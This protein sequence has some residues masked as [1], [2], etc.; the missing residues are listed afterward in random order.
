MIYLSSVVE[1][2]TM[3]QSS[4]RDFFLLLTAG[5]FL[6]FSLYVA[7]KPSED[8]PPDPVKRKVIPM[9]IE[10]DNKKIVLQPDSQSSP[11]VNEI[12][13]LQK[14]IDELKWTIKEQEKESSQKILTKIDANEKSLI[15]YRD[16]L[17]ELKKQEQQL[18]NELEDLKQNK[19]DAELA[20]VTQGLND[21][22]P[23]TAEEIKLRN[24]K[25]FFQ[26][27]ELNRNKRAKEAPQRFSPETVFLAKEN[28]AVKPL[29]AHELDPHSGEIT[30]PLILRDSRYNPEKTVVENYFRERVVLTGIQYEQFRRVEN[31]IDGIRTR[32]RQNIDEYRADHYGT[33]VTF[34]TRL[35]RQYELSF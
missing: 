1:S 28:T 21:L 5:I 31:Q 7:R 8:S 13:K 11:A 9:P 10:K 26:A 15:E 20:A 27:R 19:R 17:D 12:K 29:D 32:L 34:L 3:N 24:T 6:C 22:R 16:A 23:Q 30:W 18:V 4:L 35:S 33:A 25:A 14:Q 2:I